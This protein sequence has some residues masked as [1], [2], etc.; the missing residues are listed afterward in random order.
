M[1][2]DLES[3]KNEQDAQFWRAKKTEMCYMPIEGF[4]VRKTSN[5][6]F[7]VIIESDFIV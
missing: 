7:F 3:M 6:P 5:L 1:K 2:S 4:F